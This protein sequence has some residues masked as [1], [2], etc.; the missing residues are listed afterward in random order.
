MA[1]L[2]MSQKL[3]AKDKNPSIGIS[4]WGGR[5]NTTHIK[6]KEE[7]Q[8]RRKKILVINIMDRDHIYKSRRIRPITQ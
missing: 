2:G 4:A 7:Q 8:T 1:F 5:G 6:S 3:E